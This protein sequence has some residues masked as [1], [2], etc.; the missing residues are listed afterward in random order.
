MLMIDRKN[1]F[2][3]LAHTLLGKNVQ[4]MPVKQ[5]DYFVLN[6]CMDVNKAF[7]CW[8]GENEL[9]INSAL[10]TLTIVRQLSRGKK[11]M[12][13]LAHLLNI[14]YNIAEE[15]KVVYKRIE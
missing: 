11:T 7:K 13:E 10:Q 1:E 8:S 5:M 6:F 12:N 9:P 2:R 15:F 3:E 14:S 4:N